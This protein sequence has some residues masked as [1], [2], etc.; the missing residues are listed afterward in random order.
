[1]DPPVEMSNGAL[2]SDVVTDL[3][4]AIRSKSRERFDGLY[5]D[6]EASENTSIRENIHLI[7]SETAKSV[8]SKAER[9]AIIFRMQYLEGSIANVVWQEKDDRR[10]LAT[11]RGLQNMLNDWL[12][13]DYTEHTLTE[14][15][16]DWIRYDFWRVLLQDGVSV[17]KAPWASLPSK[18]PAGNPLTSIRDWDEL[19]VA[20]QTANGEIECLLPSA[21]WRGGN[22]RP[23][24]QAP[25]GMVL[26]ITL[27]EGRPLISRQ[28]HRRSRRR[29][30]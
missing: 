9:S 15:H 3:G 12:L 7:A 17:M 18:R 24:R 22:N 30:P 26:L 27:P 29:S 5:R 28:T 23:V 21:M 6:C 8:S 11:V 20:F 14:V 13:G 16:K 1:M 10:S 19:K 2:S 4:A 25:A